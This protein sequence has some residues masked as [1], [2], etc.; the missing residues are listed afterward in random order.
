MKQYS[1]TLIRLND[2]ANYPAHTAAT[3]LTKQTMSKTYKEDLIFRQKLFD[4][5]IN[6]IVAA[7]LIYFVSL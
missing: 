5:I 1:L 7:L 3:L 4:T 6:L 2:V